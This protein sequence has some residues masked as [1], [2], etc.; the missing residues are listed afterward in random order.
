MSPKQQRGEATVDRVLD[1]ALELYAE[2]GEAGLTLSAITQASGASAG[3]IYHHFGS[4]HGVTTALAM[5]WLGRLLGDLAAALRSTDDA[6]TGIHAIV[7]AYLDFVRAHPEAARLMHSSQADHEG[8]AHAKA[9]RDAQE[10]RLTPIAAWLQA[11]REAGELAPL[12]TPVIESL[13]M[14][15]VVGAARRWL[16]VG[17]IDL[18]EATPMLQEHIW[19]SVAPLS[20]YS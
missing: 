20:T 2:S 17:D 12:T 16:S 15:P 9:I 5:R 13:I 10:A 14:G 4:L 11:R 1:A 18:D 6:R 3:S 19:R 7:R 8:M